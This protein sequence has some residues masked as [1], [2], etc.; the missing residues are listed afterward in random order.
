MPS[1]CR[2]MRRRVIVAADSADNRQRLERQLEE[3]IYLPGLRV[4]QINDLAQVVRSVFDVKQASVEAGA[5][6]D[7]G[8]CAA[9]YARSAERDAEGPDR[10][11]AAK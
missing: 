6:E 11:Q 4:E 8:S 3:T 5:G 7:S 9:G 2:S 1:Q 10:L